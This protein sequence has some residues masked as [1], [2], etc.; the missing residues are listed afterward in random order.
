MVAQHARNL[1]EHRG[2]LRSKMLGSPVVKRDRMAVL[3]QRARQ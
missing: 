3:R 2:S 1:K